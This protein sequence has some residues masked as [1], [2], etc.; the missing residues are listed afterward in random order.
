MEWYRHLR[1]TSKIIL[2]VA[3]VLVIILGALTWQI[4]SR[5][6]G[7]IDEVAGRELAALSAQHGNYVRGVLNT[8]L[9]EGGALAASLAQTLKK[10]NAPS[11]D[12]LITM[13]TGIHE[14]NPSL[15]GC[16]T[17]WEPDA[18]DGEDGRHAGA[19]GSTADG[20]FLPYC[21]Q[22]APVVPLSESLSESYYTVPK[23]TGKAYLSNPT[24]FV[25]SGV[26]VAMSTASY[27]V[28]VDGKFRG[29][30]VVDI[31][32]QELDTLIS[33]ISVYE[34]GYAGLVTGDG[35][36]VAHKERNLVGKNLFDINRFSDP[37]QARA[38][39]QSGSTYLERAETANGVTIRYYQPV[40]LSGTDQKW[41]I[42]L[43][44][45][46]DEVLAE[47]H[48]ISNITMILCGITLLVMLG[49]IFLLVRSAVRPINYLADTARIIAGGNLKHP[50]EDSRFGGELK[51]LSTSLKNMIASLIEGIDKAQ[52]L[53][54]EAKEHSRKAQAA[55][56]QAEAASKEAQGKTE[57]MLEAA[58]K[59]EQVAQVVSSA[60]TE[61][62]AQIEQSGR[63]AG[64][65]ASVAADTAT[66]M[67]EMTAT[68]LE[69]AKNAS[70]A[71]EVSGQ[72]R[73]KA[74]EG[75]AIV[76]KSVESIR[77][78]QS[79]SLAL[80]DA[81]AELSQHA[82]SISQIMSV[83]SDIADQT[84]LLA[85]N[86][87]IEA[88]RAGEAGR[89]FAVVA[90]EVRKLAE[91]T[92]ASTIDVGNAIKAIQ[93]SAGK[94]MAQVDKAVEVIEETT[95][96]ASQSGEALRE[97]VTMADQTAAQVQGIAAASEQQSA[98]SEEINRS[99]GQVNTIASETARAM[100][101]ASRAVSDLAQQAQSLTGLIEAMKRG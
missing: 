58:D 12:T 62:S 36:V 78:V 75:A 27:P 43:V 45:P 97:I 17:M 99:V 96:Y 60:S 91:K 94:S 72:T 25:S 64:Q 57:S 84:N 92:M 19:P 18:Y 21:A 20:R 24:D 77:Q 49:V 61:L 35:L 89:G 85:L 15:F 67:E 33:G 6:A 55:M 86:A 46:Q 50:I 79:E 13:Q 83:I 11:R 40:S 68:V 76:H 3:L 30:V 48:A 63:G 95:T 65:Q 88:A 42:A 1:M 80:K 73:H 29:T 53:S 32:L 31:S 59:L 82:Q 16:G 51:I 38:A 37:A 81:M 100:E 23:A 9:N 2:P 69:V 66:A 71:S 47:A 34:T 7:A 56:E 28:M 74:E 5:T 70:T 14:G 93:D 98:A 26:T 44:V 8:A 39:F 41:Y 101:E 52:A 22:D 10:G 87:A 4:Q 90:D 54:E